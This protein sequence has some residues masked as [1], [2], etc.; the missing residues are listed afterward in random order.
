MLMCLI[1]SNSLSFYVEIST[2]L[3]DCVLSGRIAEP[4]IC[5][6]EECQARNSMTLVHNRCR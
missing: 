4:R 5:L 3:N 2:F 6:K 1:V